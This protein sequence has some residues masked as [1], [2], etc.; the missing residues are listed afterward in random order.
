MLA[1]DMLELAEKYQR[2]VDDVHRM[3]FEV[4][5]DRE[6]LVKILEGKKLIEGKWN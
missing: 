5:L 6:K 4:S 3:F 2:N 1:A